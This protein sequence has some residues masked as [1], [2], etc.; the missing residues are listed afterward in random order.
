MVRL[1]MVYCWHPMAGFTGASRNFRAR[2]WNKFFANE[3]EGTEDGPAPGQR[4][5]DGINTGT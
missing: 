3:L 2:K 1:R 4:E 5:A